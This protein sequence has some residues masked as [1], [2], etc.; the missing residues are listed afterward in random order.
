MRLIIRKFCELFVAGA[1][2]Q[3]LEYRES[4]F[5]FVDEAL[6]AFSAATFEIVM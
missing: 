3:A 6:I 1:V 2:F 4:G 5:V